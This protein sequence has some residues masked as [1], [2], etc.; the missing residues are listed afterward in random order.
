MIYQDTWVNGRLVAKGQRDCSSRY[1]LIKPVFASYGS[2]F[3]VLDIGANMC[4][5]GLRLIEDFSCT[6]MAFEF[7]SFEMRERHVKA[8]K[9]DRLILLKR[10]LTVTDL[11]ILSNSCHFDF[12]LMMSV[13]HHLPGN[14]T[15]WLNAARKIG[16]NVIIEFALDDSTRVAVRDGYKIPDDATVIGYGDSHLKQNFKRP[17]VLLK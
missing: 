15:E 10:K 9:T 11:Q 13:L 8:N 6:V 5:F 12:V 1:E 14:S 17:I 4:Y 16:D 2:G 7:N 3:S